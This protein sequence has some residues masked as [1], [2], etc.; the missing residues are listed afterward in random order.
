MK[1]EEPMVSE[2]ALERERKKGSK[3]RARRR[4]SSPELAMHAANTCGSSEK[5]FDSLGHL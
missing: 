2:E 3:G 1:L 4:R 5:K